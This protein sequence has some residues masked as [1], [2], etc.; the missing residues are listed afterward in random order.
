VGEFAVLEGEKKIVH[1]LYYHYNDIYKAVCDTFNVFNISISNSSSYTSVQKFKLNLNYI[2]DFIYD[3]D[4]DTLKYDNYTTISNKSISTTNNTLVKNIINQKEDYIRQLKT[5]TEPAGQLTERYF[6]HK[7]LVELEDSQDN[8]QI[9]VSSNFKTGVYGN[10]VQ[11]V[12]KNILPSINPTNTN[13][14]LNLDDNIWFYYDINKDK[15]CLRFKGDITEDYKDTLHLC[16]DKTLSHKITN[17]NLLNS[18]NLK[19]FHQ[20]INLV[21]L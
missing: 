17:L 3:F 18:E 12:N 20:E 19:F 6:K 1:T 13:F 9:F 5:D 10:G 4:Y 21:F 2:E 11:L 8:K 15:V 14:K 16:D 7:S